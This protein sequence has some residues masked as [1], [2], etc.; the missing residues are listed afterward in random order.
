LGLQLKF[1]PTLQRS[2]KNST[3]TPPTYALQI[4]FNSGEL[5]LWAHRGTATRRP[6]R[7]PVVARSYHDPVLINPDRDSEPVGAVW[8]RQTTIAASTFWPGWMI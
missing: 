8:A 7:S 1:A 5:E 3:L 2:A 6:P 4:A